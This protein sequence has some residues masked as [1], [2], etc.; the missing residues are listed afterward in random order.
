M[1][2]SVTEKKVYFLYWAFKKNKQKGF[3]K[4]NVINNILFLVEN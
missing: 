2:A 1:L 4:V 3:K